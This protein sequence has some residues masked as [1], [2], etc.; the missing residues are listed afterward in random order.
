MVGIRLCP[1]RLL[2]MN[3]NKKLKDMAHRNS[4]N[5]FGVADLAPAHEFILQQG[6][7]EVAGFPFAISLGIVLMK[8][9][10]DRLP[11]RSHREVALNYRHHAYNLINQ[12]LDMSA[13][14][15]SSFLQQNGYRAFPLPAAERFDDERICAE[16][17]HKLA[18]RLAGLGWIGKS[19]LLVTPQNERRE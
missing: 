1:S 3:L 17:S 14:I 18:A 4:I 16:F 12:R 8:T 5:Y 15:I 10:V 2:K 19:C 11:E 13:S 7:P 9:I 6:G